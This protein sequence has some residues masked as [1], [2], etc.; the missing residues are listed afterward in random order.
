MR[1]LHALLLAGI[2][3]CPALA[4]DAIFA[5]PAERETWQWLLQRSGR[6]EHIERDNQGHVKWVGYRK[7]DEPKGDYYSGSLTFENGH[8][9]KLTFNKAH[10]TNDDLK[11]IAAFK[12][13]KTLTAWHNWDHDDPKNTETCSGAGLVHLKPTAIES[14][15]FGG[16]RFN[17]AGMKASLELPQLKELIVYHT[18]VTDTGVAA[19]ADHPGLTKVVLG[20]QHSQRVT[21]ASLEPLSRIK[22]LKHLE[23]NET[24]LSWEGGLKHL[25]RLKDQLE[26][27]TCKAGYIPEADLAQ[28]KQALPNTKIEYTP[29]DE[30]QLE[31]MQRAAQR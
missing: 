7:E 22:H 15:N 14:I 27:F 11:R 5:D 9:V 24:M 26:S 21:E 2:L 23:L 17:D 6:S 25:A 10:F 30:K 3:V 13:L 29:A 4:D 1:I 19:I 12:H 31:R 16:S 28:L 20:P 18:F 8:V